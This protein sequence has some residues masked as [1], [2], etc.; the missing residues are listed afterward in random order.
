MGRVATYPAHQHVD[1]HD[2][3]SR[4]LTE[5]SVGFDV[6]PQNNTSH[7]QTYRSSTRR[8]DTD[9]QVRLVTGDLQSVSISVVSAPYLGIVGVMADALGSRRRGLPQW[10]RRHIARS[11]SAEGHAAFQPIVHP[12]A[13]IAPDCI[14]LAPR[15]DISVSHQLS[16]LRDA[17]TELVLD[18]LRADFGDHIPPQWRGAAERPREWLSGYARAGE[19]AYDV[20]KPVW[21]RGEALIQREINRV[22]SAVV[23]GA[24]DVL[25]ADLHPRVSF[26]DG[27]FTMD[28]P[29]PGE[30][31]LAGRRLVLVPTLG[32]QAAMVANFGLDDIVWISYPVRGASALWR[33]SGSAVGQ[34]TQPNQGTSSQ[35][36]SSQ[37]ASNQGALGEILGPMRAG[38]LQ[39]LE[40]PTSVSALA[41]AFNCVPA[42]MTYQCDRLV[43]AGLIA[44]QRRGREVR[45]SRT[46]R[47]SA[48]LD[49]LME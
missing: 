38:V 3:L 37:G 46:E 19:E 33:L 29:E 14:A 25:M 40:S 39:A 8:G 11:I 21:G 43:S 48:L 49:L 24:A 34:G 27:T 12:G 13:S 26:Q 2:T 4:V 20:L 32:A 16:F 30:F 17:P 44:R 10:W 18:D 31:E 7:N 35:G 36:A 5:G 9:S 47:G 15:G 28:D 42:T 6:M 41:A 23:R 45:V 1:G 22:G